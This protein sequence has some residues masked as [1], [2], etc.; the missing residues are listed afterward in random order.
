MIELTALAVLIVEGRRGDHSSFAEELEEKGY[1]VTRSPSGNA[2]LDVIDEVD[3]D[4]VVVDAASLRTSGIRICQSFRK[5][6]LDLPIILIVTRDI[7]LPED[8]DANLV[9]RLPFTIQKLVNRL[10]AYH[11]T[12]EKY[13]MRAGPIELNTKTQL[14]TCEDRQ[15]K[16]TPRL[17]EIMEILIKNNGKVV[18]RNP[19][20]TRV[21]DTSY[22]GDTRTLD[23]HIS[24]LRQAIEEDPSNPRFIRTKRGVGYILD[25]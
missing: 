22:T 15:T 9:L 13:I 24:W 23:V 11:N 16:L 10:Q 20:F 17:V 7:S 6:K 14:I 21:W 18:E 12:D 8:V 1:R 19:L 5:A 4:V 2:G 25:V 3:P